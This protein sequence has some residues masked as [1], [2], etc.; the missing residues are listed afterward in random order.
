MD[1]RDRIRKLE[2][3]L[4]ALQARETDDDEARTQVVERPL[5][6]SDSERIAALESQLDELIGEARSV[7]RAGDQRP[8]IQVIQ[9]TDV[10]GSGRKLTGREK[11]EQ[12]HG[13]EKLAQ[14]D[15]AG[16]VIAWGCAVAM[17]LWAAWCFSL[18]AALP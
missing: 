1:D 7:V 11:L 6:T 18:S 4:E 12:K 14:A 13:Q 16:Q 15:K 3:Q 10:G 17:V 2:R 8:A 9:H 5:T